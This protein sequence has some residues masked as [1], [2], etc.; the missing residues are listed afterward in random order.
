MPIVK[1]NKDTSIDNIR[2]KKCIL[3]TY[4]KFHSVS[5]L[6]CYSGRFHLFQM[7]ILLA[8]NIQQAVTLIL[9]I[10]K[11]Y[12]YQ[13]FKTSLTTTNVIE[14]FLQKGKEFLRF[15]LSNV[16]SILQS[17]SSDL[18]AISSHNSSSRFTTVVSISKITSTGA[19]CLS[20][21]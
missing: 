9:W 11:I 20:G 8:K 18:S 13:I 17:I 3:L 6:V 15:E 4:T 2:L 5:N 14:T 1:I 12:H 19:R 16:S 7:T 10:I 21:K